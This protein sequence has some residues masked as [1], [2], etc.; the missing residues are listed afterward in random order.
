MHKVWDVF[1]MKRQYRHLYLKSDVLL[2]ADIFKI[3]EVF[4]KKIMG[5]ILLGT[6]RFQFLLG[7]LR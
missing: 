4:I 7:M 3:S 5:W 1:N 2:L 6:T